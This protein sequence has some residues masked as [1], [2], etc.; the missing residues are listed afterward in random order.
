MPRAAVEGDDQGAG[1][2]VG[3]RLRHVEREAVPGVRVAARVRELGRAG[4]ARRVA[5][6]RCVR[7]IAA[8]FRVSLLSAPAGRLIGAPLSRRRQGRGSS[9]MIGQ[10]V[11]TIGNGR[12]RKR[13]GAPQLA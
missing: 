2:A 8:H 9:A 11:R 3:D 7:T 10:G 12:A 1:L 13:V 5:D 6:G 4:A